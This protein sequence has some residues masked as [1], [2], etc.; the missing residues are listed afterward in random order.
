MPDHPPLVSAVAICYN[1]RRFLEDCLD[2]VRRQSYPRVQLIV[3]D[4]C[5]TDGSAEA[6]EEWLARTGTA[7][8]F[9]AHDTN[10]GICATRN[11]ALTLA[12][13]DYVACISTDDMWLEDKLAVQVD[14]MERQAQ[15]VAV[16][17]G[18]AAMIDDAGN[19]LPTG[20][21]DWLRGTSFDS[22]PEGDVYAALLEA[23]FVPAA[24]TLIRRW[25]LEE[26][27]GYDESLAFEDWDMWLRLA[28]RWRFGFTPRVVA[29][30]RI[31]PDSL[32]RQLCSGPRQA[33]LA[34]SM[35]RIMSKHLGYTP[36]WDRVLR[37]RM[38]AAARKLYTYDH[39]RA[40]SY[41]L[42]A[43]RHDPHLSTWA[44]YVLA[45]AGVDHGSA[46]RAHDRV[47]RLVAGRGN[48]AQ[49]DRESD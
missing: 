16:V 3:I 42:T 10:H 1:H 31:L 6:I 19:P 41:L 49:G 25:A 37:R 22:P 46:H 47:R 26:A 11:E 32:W 33:D 28:R 7:A 34:A 2:S 23:S 43:A 12:R 9:R 18:D 35:V 38:T 14:A 45:L 4:D 36:D 5:S 24:T 39:R 13:G 21:L 27:G 44:M 30:Y 29:R 40:R 48:R 8:E 17:Y 20:Y 15:S